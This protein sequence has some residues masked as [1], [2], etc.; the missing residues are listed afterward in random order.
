[1]LTSISPLKGRISLAEKKSVFRLAK[2][3]FFV[4]VLVFTTASQDAVALTAT[5]TAVA[6]TWVSGFNASTNYGGSSEFQADARSSH[7]RWG[8]LK[9][10]MPALS[11]TISSVKLRVYM[12]GA[13][14]GDTSLQINAYE[15]SQT[16]WGEYTATY[17]TY[18]G[19]NAWS[20]VPPYASTTPI[21]LSRNV[22]SAGWQ[23][24]YLV[25]T[26]STTNPITLDWS[27]TFGIRIG[28]T[29]QGA[30]YSSIAMTSRE[31]T[32][33]PYIEI[34][35]TAD[36]V[37]GCMDTSATNYSAEADTPDN[38][39]VYADI[40]PQSGYVV[41]PTHPINSSAIA[42]PQMF[43]GGVNYSYVQNA[44]NTP[45]WYSDLGGS[46]WYMYFPYELKSP[47]RSIYIIGDPITNPNYTRKCQVNGG[48]VVGNAQ[49]FSAGSFYLPDN[50]SGTSTRLVYVSR[51][52]IYKDAGNCIWFDL[53]S[54]PAGHR[55]YK[56]IASPDNSLTWN[57]STTFNAYVN[58]VASSTTSGNTYQSASTTLATCDSLDIGC[59][60]GNALQFV[61]VPDPL[62][63]RKFENL[64]LASSSPFSYAYDIPRLRDELLNTSTTTVLAWTLPFHTQASTTATVS[65]ISV[66]QLEAIPFLST[67][68]TILGWLLWVAFAELV[69][70][71]ILRVHNKEHTT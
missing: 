20:Q 22:T 14:D 51:F 29:A 61:F 28:Y 49:H 27:E 68:R 59:Y 26:A 65:L 11:G 43:A 18:D 71:Q 33:K 10:N 24:F 30:T 44:S 70:Y 38:S 1:M 41:T 25:G 55:I 69:Y 23:D 9:F 57:S 31:G 21:S 36:P 62:T 45:Y 42:L 64:T 34:T 32:N 58:A 37:Y 46:G 47:L 13:M 4:S 17:N 60:F 66:A 39:C 7:N 63:I 56:V 2:T 12:Q 50:A 19:T 40:S 54:I 48:T 67:I 6:D 5:T 15:M 35:Y 53:S 3:L 8:Y 52:D 16:N